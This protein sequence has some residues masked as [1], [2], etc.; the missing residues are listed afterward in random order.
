MAKIIWLASYPKSGNT[1]VRFIV[2]NLICGNIESSDVVHRLVPD[3]HTGISWQHLMRNGGLLLKTHLKYFKEM[4]LRE[5]TI[6][7]VYILRNPLDVIVSALNYSELRSGQKNK[8]QRQ[9]F[10]AEFIENGGLNEWKRS[11]FGTWD[12]HVRSWHAKEMPFPRLTLRYED[13]KA[14]PVKCISRLCRFSKIERSEEEIN[15]A[16]AASSF[17]NMRAMEERE[18]A[19]GKFGLFGMENRKNSSGKRFMNKG[20]TGT[21]R[22]ALTEDQIRAVCGRFAPVMSQ[23]NYDV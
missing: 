2:A 5:D 8:E 9:A 17:S 15:D 4:P 23:F 16:L 6:G 11:G 3:F 7:V 1:W 18:V 20:A 19:V 13:L 21:Y 14:S 12:E 22:E 10:I